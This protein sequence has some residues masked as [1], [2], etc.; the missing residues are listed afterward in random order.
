LR[1]AAGLNSRCGRAVAVSVAGAA[2]RRLGSSRAV[3]RPHLLLVC[4]ACRLSRFRLTSQP[5]ARALGRARP[6]VSPPF[7][8]PVRALAPMARLCR[9]CC[10][11]CCVRLA[12]IEAM[13]VRLCSPAVGTEKVG[14]LTLKTTEMETVYDLGA[15]M[16]DALTRE[17]VRPP[18]CS[19]VWQ[20]GPMAASSHTVDTA[21][22][23]S[24]TPPGGRAAAHD[25]ASLLHCACT[26]FLPPPRRSP[27]ATSSRS[28]RP[29]GA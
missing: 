18:S 4:A 28:T 13:C 16:I 6:P 12:L 26:L 20:S 7:S 29:R 21:K 25:H 11:C 24:H 17:K 14:K 15:K 22:A 2:L 23:D 3:Y 8:W 10:V 19:A 5:P 27:R 9:F 1:R